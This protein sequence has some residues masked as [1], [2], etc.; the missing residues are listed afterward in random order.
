MADGLAAQCQRRF[1]TLRWAPT[2][3]SGGMRRYYSNHEL[4]L[5]RSHKTQLWGQATTDT[6]GRLKQFFEVHGSWGNSN[7]PVDVSYFVNQDVVEFIPEVSYIN[8]LE[9][10]DTVIIDL[11]PKS[12]ELFTFEHLRWATRAVLMV[13]TVKGG[14]LDVHFK[15]LAHKLRFSGSRSFHIYIRLDK[16]YPMD[17]IRSVLKQNL[18]PLTA[19][20]PILSYNNSRGG[21][22][23][24]PPRNDFILIDCG[25]LSR[26][27]CVRSLWSVHNKTKRICVP[28]TDLESFQPQQSEPEYVLKQG[29][30]E[31]VF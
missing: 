15:I 9:R 4:E 26:H 3:Q 21:P 20:H 18:D 14:P 19:M 2:E 30:Q 23:M 24:G 11:D 27:R 8:D 13:T 5:L 6:D 10:T 29:P 28:L 7:N 31:E 16:L 12:P 25:A 1:V 17:D 22:K